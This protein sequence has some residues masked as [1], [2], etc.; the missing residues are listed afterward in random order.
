MPSSGRP[1]I[2][3]RVPFE[4]IPLGSD[5]RFSRPW[6][7]FFLAL[8][9]NASN[10]VLVER[11]SDLIGAQNGASAESGGMT[12]L[13]ASGSGQSDDSDSTGVFAHAMLL[14]GG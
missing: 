5:K 6:H 2:A 4:E 12:V 13:I 11:E 1:F 7:D 8:S 14:M 3:I 9:Q 10:A